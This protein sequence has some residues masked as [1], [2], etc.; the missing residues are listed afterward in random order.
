MAAFTNN[1]VNL[2]SLDFDTLKNSLTSYLANQGQFK[3]YNFAGSNMSVLLDVLTYNTYLNAFYLNMVASE[4]FLDSAQIRDSVVSH[5]KMLNYLPRS[6]TSSTTT[7]N[8]KIPTSNAVSFTIPSGT[9]FGGKNN[10]GNYTFI[11]SS[12]I[13]LNSGNNTFVANNL[14]VY[15]GTYLQESFVI[16]YTNQTQ[17]FQL[18]SNT[19]DTSSLTVVVVENSGANITDFQF[20]SSLYGLGPSSNV[21]FLQ[22]STGGT[23]QLVFGDNVFGRTPL[24][25]SVITVQYRTC[26]GSDANS[27]DTLT[28]ETDLGSLNG[29]AILSGLTVVTNTL[30]S[31]GANAEGIES[32]RYNAPR[33]FQTQER[34]VTTADYQDLI[35]ENFPDIESVG[36]FGGETSTGA[37]EYG[38]VFISTTTYSGTPLSTSRKQDVATFLSQRMNLGI[39]AVLIDPDYTYVTL[40]SNV[41]VD[42]TQTS[43]T[44][45]EITT[46]VKQSITNYNTQYLQQFGKDFRLSNLMT[47]I[48]LT[49]SSIISNETKAFVYKILNLPL[50]VASTL[51]ANFNFAIT[52]GTLL[53]NQFV[54]NGANYVYTDYVP[55]V[56]NTNGTLYKVLQ[57]PVSNVVS[58]SPAGTINYTTG[59]V[60]ISSNIYAAL[61]NSI[62]KLFALPQNQ[63][64]YSVNNQVIE[65]DIASGLVVNTVSG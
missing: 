25:G 19:I 22:A 62:L 28:I 17:Q 32:I 39:T 45:A 53:T 16:D 9:P 8:V 43:L 31:G 11:T 24:N 47:A 51:T 42:F 26:S 14:P 33:H 46:A 6:Y 34:A 4:M 21:Y 3:D 65:I 54:S 37:V 29:T 41:H 57:N 23:Y 12:S 5:A 15:E 58:Y 20:A 35:L 36:V 61:N 59:A 40:S 56:T 10:I 30:T 49:D 1:S 64:L 2:A 48:N 55:G 27:V 52:P 63:D 13:T 38:K 44:P 50:N 18:S 60:S 7:I